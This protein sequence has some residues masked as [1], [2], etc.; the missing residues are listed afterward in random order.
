MSEGVT[1]IGLVSGAAHGLDAP[2]AGNMNVGQT[3]HDQLV[4]AARVWVAQTFFGQMLRQM[5]NSPFKSDLFE[6]GRGG[7][8]FANQ[9]DQR[10]AE[11]M[12]GSK[13][14]DRIVNSIVRRIEGRSRIQRRSEPNVA[15]THRTA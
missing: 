7:Q 8:A 6:G 3:Q 2:E 9:L 15:P 1:S 10:L 4:R 11:R 14:A 12:A 5:R 13:A